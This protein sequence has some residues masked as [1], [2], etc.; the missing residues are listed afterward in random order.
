MSDYFALLNEPRR[1]WLDAEALKQRFLEASA[2]AHPD[3]YH[4]ASDADRDQANADF[5]SLNQAYQCLREPK[6]RLGYLLQL[7]LGGK[8]KDIQRIPPGATDLF[9]EVGLL[10]RE[11]D[12]FLPEKA[13][14]AS[15]IL[16]VRTFE[17]S[18]QLTDKLQT[19][20]QKISAQ[21]EQLLAELK[22]MNTL[23]ESAPET[24][25][26]RAAALPL[27]RLEQIYR[28]LSY[29]GRWSAQ[30]QERLVQLSF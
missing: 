15:P 25:P 5:A 14:A 21:R 30:I 29:I 16:K 12:A 2:T 6:E 22:T 18:L 1:P 26:T 11:V 24:A 8:P 28:S 27:E 20:Q 4:G 7:E 17:T 10:C 23:W 9:M 19:L 3:R 13:K